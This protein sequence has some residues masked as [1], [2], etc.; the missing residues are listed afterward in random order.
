M[1]RA[2]IACGSIQVALQDDLIVTLIRQ[3]GKMKV[4]GEIARICF[5]DAYDIIYEAIQD[6][7]LSVELVDSKQPTIRIKG[8][9]RQLA[10][11]LTS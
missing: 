5:P 10:H 2:L 8:G 7:P 4:D 1:I 11:M 6:D 9:E 3:D